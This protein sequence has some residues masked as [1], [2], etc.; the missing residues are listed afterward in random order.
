MRNG[1][2]S[3]NVE[4]KRRI[5]GV[6]ETFEDAMLLNLKTRMDHETRKADAPRKKWV[7]P[8][9]VQ[10]ISALEESCIQPNERN[11]NF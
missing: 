8:W 10:C 6:R 7:L 4:E 3:L 1:N 5:I 2:C 11:I 9:S